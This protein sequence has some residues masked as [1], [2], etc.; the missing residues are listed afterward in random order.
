[1]ES[2]FLKNL[3]QE[4]LKEGESIREREMFSPI[5]RGSR[6]TEAALLL[7]LIAKTLTDMKA[8]VTLR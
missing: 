7:P 1:M 2:N 8:D 4:P 6:L 5:K 3:Q